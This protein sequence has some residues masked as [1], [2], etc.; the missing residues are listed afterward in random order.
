[1]NLN[2]N[3]IVKLT[4]SCPGNCECCTNRQ[5]SFLNKK[6]TNKPFDIHVFEKICQN[7]IKLNGSYVCL[8]GGEPT[9]VPEIDEYIKIAHDYALSVRINTNGWGITEE[10]LERWLKNGLDQVVLSV[11]SLEPYT[12]Q[13]T[14]GNPEIYKRTMQAVQ[15]LKNARQSQKFMFIMQTII[16]R[17]NYREL[18]DLLCF[19]IDNSCDRFWPSYLEDA[20]N[21]PNIRMTPELVQEFRHEIVPRM[22]QVINKKIVNADKAKGLNEVIEHYYENGYD[23]Y[24]YHK[25]GE[26]CLWSG[27]HFTF[28]PNGTI[29]PCPGHEY[30]FSPYQFHI[31]YKN[32]DEFMTLESLK[33]NEGKVF[34]YCMYCPQGKHQEININNKIIHEHANREEL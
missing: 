20:I 21:L 18:P 19:A 11:Y 25:Q 10:K 7:I 34:D 1:M 15:I 6:E 33:K 9:I 12:M 2:Y 8:S 13:L 29:D 3:F 31:D 22:K 14:R 27:S 4:L 28:Y 32:I 30:F 26:C 24:I 16:M 17:H 5:N 23:G